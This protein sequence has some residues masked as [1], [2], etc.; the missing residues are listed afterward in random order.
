MHNGHA[1]AL[2]TYRAEHNKIVNPM[3]TDNRFDKVMNRHHEV[4]T[5]RCE[6]HKSR[7]YKFEAQETAIN[8]S[9]SDHCNDDIIN[10]KYDNV[11]PDKN[12]AISDHYDDTVNIKCDDT[13]PGQSNKKQVVLNISE[14]DTASSTSKQ[15][16]TSTTK[17]HTNSSTGKRPFQKPIMKSIH[18]QLLRKRYAIHNYSQIYQC[19]LFIMTLQL[20]NLFFLELR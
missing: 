8:K 4:T 12:N 14:G 19:M 17:T 15:T 13:S 10:V 18:K 16:A 7:G 1:I 5:L 11:I 2:H 20:S 3:Y 6:D 9:S